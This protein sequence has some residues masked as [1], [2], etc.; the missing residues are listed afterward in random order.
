MDGD[1]DFNEITR[2]FE[3][4]GGRLRSKRQMVGFCDVL[5]DCGLNDLGFTGRWYTWE[6]GRFLA[7][8]KWERIDQTV[9]S[10]EWQDMF[11]D[12]V[13]EHLNHAFSNHCLV[14]LDSY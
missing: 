3:K 13:V 4:K 7:T 1:R 10:L 11:S 6:R 14:L 8:N 2:S 9:A 5:T 12:C